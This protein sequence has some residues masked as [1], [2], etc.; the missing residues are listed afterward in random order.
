MNKKELGLQRFKEIL[1]AHSTGTI[2]KLSNISEDFG[3][4]ILEIAYGEFYSRSGITDKTREVAIVSCLIGQGNT[5]L[6]L[7]THLN[8][9]MNV[10]HS[11]NEII[12][13]LMFLI[14]CV[15]FPKIV[16]AMITADDLFR[17]Q[18]NKQQISA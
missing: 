13:L 2:E 8:G 10:G 18:E 5:G 15:G 12:E 3:N 14:P 1:G 4:Y 16:E 6:P 17:S 9:M 11:K 7:K